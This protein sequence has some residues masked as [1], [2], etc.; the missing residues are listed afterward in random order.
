[1]N[2]LA[3]HIADQPS[4]RP[5]WAFSAMMVIAIH[6]ALIALGIA[7]YHQAPPPGVAIPAILIDMSPSSA[8]PQPQPLDVAPGP[9]MQQAEEPEPPPPPP[10]EP[11]K[12]AE[13]EPLLPTPPQP[14]PEVAAPSE[15][16]PEPQAQPRREPPPEPTTVVPEPT[17]PEPAKKPVKKPVKKPR[18][19]PAP[20]TSAA[21]AAE[22]QGRAA[23]SAAAGASA[24][25]A[26]PAYRDR[27]AAHLQRYK[28]YPASAR[29]AGAQGTAMLSFTVSRS[30][31]VLRASLSRSSG[32]AELDAETLA[33]VRRAQP[34]PAFPP[35]MPQSS[36]SFTVPVRFAIR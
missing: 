7:W 11:P 29:S 35:E 31:Q 18:E 30:G 3:L 33:M 14:A 1:M 25:A 27:L 22:R 8:S 21:P 26:M 17:K 28:Q 15:P 24:A 34:L 19:T 5:R 32:H 6:A 23:A 20:R 16:K 10:P 36:M 13:P 4:E 2:A 12:P 9:E